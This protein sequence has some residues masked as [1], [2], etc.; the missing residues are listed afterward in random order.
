[1]PSL[2]TPLSS[3]LTYGAYGVA[4]GSIT[5]FASGAPGISSGAMPL[6][7]KS[8]EVPSTGAVGLFMSSLDQCG[9]WNGGLREEWEVYS[10]SALEN[11]DIIPSSC[12]QGSYSTNYTTIFMSGGVTGSLQRQMPLYIGNSGD[13]V[14]HAYLTSFMYAPAFH[15]STGTLFVSGYENS[16][17]VATIY[18]SGSYYSATGTATLYVEGFDESTFSARMYISGIE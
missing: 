8:F 10:T 9:I 5:I 15:T 7:I 2:F 13:G 18:V 3:I 16:S 12:T 11:W 17:G 1:M 14:E 6:F 4:S